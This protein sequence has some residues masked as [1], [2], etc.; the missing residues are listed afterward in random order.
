MKAWGSKP[1]VYFMVD[2]M[3]GNALP[4]VCVRREY[5]ME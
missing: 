1:V 5:G 2:R 3:D 4:V